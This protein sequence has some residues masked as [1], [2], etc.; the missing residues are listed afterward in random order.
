[1]DKPVYLFQ[2]KEIF[3][4]LEELDRIT[5]AWIGS[6]SSITQAQKTF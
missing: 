3:V 6:N 2:N 5:Q 1:M 4:Q